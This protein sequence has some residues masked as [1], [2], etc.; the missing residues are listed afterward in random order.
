[1]YKKSVF[2]ITI[3][4]EGEQSSKEV[5]GMV[6]GNYGFYKEDGEYYPTYLPTGHAL[7]IPSPVFNYCRTSK[8][9]KEVIMIYKDFF[10]ENIPVTERY[11]KFCDCIIPFVNVPSEVEQQLKNRLRELF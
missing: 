5:T 7:P 4:S 10:G 2:T 6:W 8:K 9:A 11:N 1:M 3:I